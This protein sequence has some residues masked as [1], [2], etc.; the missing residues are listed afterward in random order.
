MANHVRTQIRDAV[1]TAV[2]SLTTTGANVFKARPEEKPLQ[3]SEL[4][5]LIVY[6]DDESDEAGTLQRT[7]RRIIRTMR[8]KVRGYAKSTGDLDATLD[9]IDKEVETAIDGS[10]SVR[11]LCKELYVESVQ[12]APQEAE[13]EKP[14]GMV[15]I[16]YFVEYHTAQGS[17][18]AALA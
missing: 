8:L 14:V 7:G 16:A 18:D 11:A 6:T 1:V 17:P 10:S 5:A 15:E 9:T 2:T 4:P 13:G 3:A 12:K